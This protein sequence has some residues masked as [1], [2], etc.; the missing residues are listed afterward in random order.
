MIRSV[1]SNLPESV[2]DRQAKIALRTLEKA[3][4]RLDT[5][6]ISSKE[7]AI[8]P[9][10]SILIYTIHKFGSYIGSD[11][12]GE[13][14]KPAEKVGEEAALSF[15]NEYS[16]LPEVDSH[17]GDMIVPYLFLSPFYSKVKVSKITSHL[18]TN[19][20]VSSLFVKRKYSFIPLTGD[21][22]ILEIFSNS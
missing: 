6:V 20:F 8:S 7:T 5:K 16:I 11:S 22:A 17:L 10:T 21:G 9:G 13:R 14:G 19:L 2:A 4:I 3:K 15:L 18:K 1:C 12:I